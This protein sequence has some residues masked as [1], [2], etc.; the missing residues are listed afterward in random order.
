MKKIIFVNLFM[1]VLLLI[2]YDS[3]AQLIVTAEIRPRL[4]YRN[5]YRIPIETSKDFA[6]FVSQRTRLNLLYSSNFFNIGISVQDVRVWGDETLVS[7]TGVFGDPASLDLKEAWI[8]I[9]FSNKG[10]SVKMGRQFLS[11]DDERLLAKRNW[12]QLSI[13]YDAVLFSTI[14]SNW[15]LDICGSYNNSKEDIF[16]SEYPFDRMKTLSFIYYKQRLDDHFNFSVITLASG[17]QKR[18][19]QTIY[20]RGT[21]GLNIFFKEKHLEASGTGY[22]Q[23]GKSQYGQG[24][25]AFFLSAKAFYK[26]SKFKLGAGIDYISGQDTTNNNSSYHEKDHLFDIL[27]GARHKYYGY[28]DYFSYIPSSTANAGLIDI[29]LKLSYTLSDKHNF[30]IDYHYLSLAHMIADPA[31]AGSPTLQTLE[32]ALGSEVDIS[33]QYTIRKDINVQ[34]GFSFFLP[35]S[36][37]EVMKQVNDLSGQLSHWAYV[38][39]TVKPT[40]F[41]N[42]K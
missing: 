5:G 8:E 32:R 3:Q 33:Y 22:Y 24:V 14:K 36:T 20:M 1:L 21:Y 42:E 10:L 12:N 38:M 28:M 17:Y 2:T 11:Y 34:A 40:L 25:N 26:F 30:G 37:L 16:A 41:S 18:N 31:S 4:E 13:A 7:P 39:V 35:T 27:Y 19:T 23:N 15:Q 9:P 6:L 29:Y